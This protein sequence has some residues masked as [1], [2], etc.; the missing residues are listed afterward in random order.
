MNFEEI[1]KELSKYLPDYLINNCC[2]KEIIKTYKKIIKSEE[3]FVEVNSD[4]YQKSKKFKEINNVSPSGFK[5]KIIGIFT[6][7]NIS[8]SI[9]LKDKYEIQL[10][11]LKKLP[12]DLYESIEI[13]I[14]IDKNQS[15]WKITTSLENED[16]YCLGYNTEFYTYNK[17]NEQI[18]I[19]DIELKK[20]KDFFIEL[21]V[22][23]NEA[24]KCRLNF[25]ENIEYINNCKK[26]QALEKIDED[27]KR[28]NNYFTTPF[29]I[30]EFATFISGIKDITEDE[31]EQ[32]QEILEDEE[33]E[34]EY[35]DYTNEQEELDLN[36]IYSRA[37]NIQESLINHL[38]EEGEFIMSQ[39]IYTSIEN[40]L[41]DKDGLLRTTGIIIRKL[42]NKYTFYYTRMT[43]ED[44]ILIKKNTTKEEIID[45][46]NKE[47]LN[48]KIY[49]L[50]EFFETTKNYK[51]DNN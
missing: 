16:Y 7:E 34:E 10:L 8:L 1:I 19:D 40:Y 49:G 3:I 18:E 31:E 33:K 26:I 23:L 51:L 14:L 38:G 4:I 32:E 27:Y 48:A 46:Y 6:K 28:E 9:E 35:D 20:D 41:N 30:T 13:Y 22:P 11:T 50:K 12:N 39:N 21:G 29:I 43:E 36:E 25:N 47:P 2:F 44:I 15:T 24:R 17:N 5:N 45:L 42:S 37:Y